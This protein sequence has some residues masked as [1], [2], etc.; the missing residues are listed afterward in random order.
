MNDTAV[1]TDAP[2]REGPEIKPDSAGRALPWAALLVLGCSALL[3]AVSIV[4]KTPLSTALPLVLAAIVVL[5]S[6]AVGLASRRRNWT[7]RL[8]A[9]EEECRAKA[10]ESLAWQSQLADSRKTEEVLAKSLAEARAHL[11]EL[12]GQR[13]LLQ[14][15][16][17][18]RKRVERTLSQ[19][20]QALESSKTVL[21]MHVE[22]STLELE[23]LQ[24]R[25]EL[26]LNSAGEGICGLDP[27][28]KATFVNPAVTKITGWS[29]AELIGKSEQEIFYQN[30]SKGHTESPDAGFGEQLFYRKDGTRFPVEFVRTKIEEHGHQTGSVLIFKDITER[31]RT[32]ENLSQKAAELARSNA[33]LEQFA[34]VASHDLQEPLRKIH[35]FGDRLK[36][37]LDQALGPEP[38]EYLDRMQNAAARMRTLIDDLLAFS[39]VIRSAE[40]FL[41]ISLTQITKEVIGDLEVRIEKNAARVEVGD[42]PTIDADAT[43]MR[44][45]MLNLIGNALKF[46]PPN[47]QP[48]VKVQGRTVTSIS[49]EQFCELTVQDNGIGFEERYAEKIFVVFQRL[50]GRG[51]YERT[52][53]GLAVCRR[54][55]D[56]HQ[57]T[58]VAQSKLGQGATF[59]VRL[60][61][62]QSKPKAPNE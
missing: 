24:D 34:F 29:L 37:K 28:G 53:V 13:T 43:Q 1:L 62:H 19:Q 38:R 23:K 21:E 36:A 5:G 16:L 32:E 55:T 57:G 58:I 44:Q 15:E 52:G 41:P 51:E 18:S 31:K 2:L 48:V 26:I 60:P 9:A 27:Q 25:Y 7:H 47:G 14:S 8:T 10:T 46:Q 35:A 39:R 11:T 22:A 20:R 56:R 17:D 30:G 42:L 45:L 50:H 4:G 61:V 49:G 54:I 40:P 33:E 3:M 59:T 12:A 6:F